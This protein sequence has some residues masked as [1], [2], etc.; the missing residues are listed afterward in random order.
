MAESRGQP[1]SLTGGPALLTPRLRL[2]K[3]RAEDEPLVAA[4]NRDPEVT[5]YLNRPVD[6]PAAAAFFGVLSQHWTHHGF[7]FYAVEVRKT[8]QLIGFAGAAYPSFLPELAN[9][10]ELGWR[11]SRDAWG[12]GYAAEAARAARQHAF[13]R[14]AL[15]ELISII[16]PENVRSRRLARKLGM[17]IERTVHNPVLQRDGDV[18]QLSRPS[19]R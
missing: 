7:G 18:W 6:G 17:A 1:G 10:A 16:H 3:W 12:Y 13:E 2:R 4:V 19:A 9:R 11:L 8:G 5:R 14:L 15:P